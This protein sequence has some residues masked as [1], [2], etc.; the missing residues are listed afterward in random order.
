[1]RARSRRS[2]FVRSFGEFAAK[3]NLD[4]A[5]RPHYR[6]LRRR[7][8]E[9]DVGANVFRTHHAVRAAVGLARN[10]GNLRNCRFGKGIEQ[11]RTVLDDTAVLLR[12]AWKETGY[13]FESHDRNVKAVTEA[14][15][16]RT[17]QRAVDVQNAGKICR[18]IRDDT[19]RAAVE[20]RKAHDDVQRIVTMDFKEVAVVNNQVD[21]FA[22]IVRLVGSFRNDRIEFHLNP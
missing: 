22:N 13:V 19:N 18:L 8:G 3:R 17:L 15:K 21:H 5:C 14:Y 2:S 20:T 4:G 7:P 12:N 1:M 11:L 9:V 10:Y 16:A 6:N